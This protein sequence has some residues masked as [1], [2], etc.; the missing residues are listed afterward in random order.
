MRLSM[1]AKGLCA[2][3]IASI[4]ISMG[5]IIAVHLG[6]DP[7]IMRARFTLSETTAVSRGDDSADVIP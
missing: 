5:H 1:L 3:S 2:L 6:S 7:K 4:D